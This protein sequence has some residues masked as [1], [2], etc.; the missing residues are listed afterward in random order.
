MA[1]KDAFTVTFTDQN[2]PEYPSISCCASWAV[3]LSPPSDPTPGTCSDDQVHVSFPAGTY[4]GVENFQVQI[5]HTYEDD[6][7]VQG[8]KPLRYEVHVADGRF[9]IASAKLRIMKKLSSAC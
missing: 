7:L 8:L 9:W 2:T 6:R 1:D 3:G 4:Y 5:S